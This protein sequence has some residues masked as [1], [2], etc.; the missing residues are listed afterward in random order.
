MH[1]QASVLI[2][3]LRYALHCVEEDSKFHA[4]DPEVSEL[5]NSILRGIT[6]LER[7]SSS[8]DQPQAA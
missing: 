2:N 5:K 1:P 8:L 3:M 7:V 6:E 4:D